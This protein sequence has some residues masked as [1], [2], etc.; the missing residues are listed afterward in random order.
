[1]GFPQL[2]PL[3]YH[4]RPAEQPPRYPFV[5]TPFLVHLNSVR[6]I[7]LGF[8]QGFL[9]GTELS[10]YRGDGPLEVFGD[11][12]GDAHRKTGPEYEFLQ[13]GCGPNIARTGF[14]SGLA[15]RRGQLRDRFDDEDGKEPTRF[16]DPATFSQ[17]G[18]FLFQ[19]AKDVGMA[20]RVED[21]IPQREMPS[22]RA[23]DARPL[24]E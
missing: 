6:R 19:S 5:H 4:Q 20:N 2:N 13:R 12:F 1:M 16:Q 8:P 17:H 23:E 3:S 21:A 9:P 15:L 7:S 11:V 10:P 24:T 22:V 14:C 18:E